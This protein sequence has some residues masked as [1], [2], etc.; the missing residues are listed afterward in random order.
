M[1][2]KPLPSFH[3]YEPR[4]KIPPTSSESTILLNFE[5][6]KETKNCVR[7]KEIPEAGKSEVIGTLYLKK[8]FAGNT[9]SIEISINKK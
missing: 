3:F 1:E 5:Y 4:P 2:S 7:Y 6:E 9:Q 8:F